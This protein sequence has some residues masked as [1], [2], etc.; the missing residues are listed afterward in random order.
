MS[1]AGFEPKILARE[2][3]KTHA[4]GRMA[5]GIDLMKSSLTQIKQGVSS[6]NL[7]LQGFIPTVVAINFN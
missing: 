6:L 1:P 3:P 4:L 2:L 5:T 7:L